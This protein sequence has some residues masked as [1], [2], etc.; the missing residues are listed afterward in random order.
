MVPKIAA[1]AMLAVLAAC[2]N[3]RGSFCDLAAPI[4]LSDEQIATLTDEQVAQ[5]LGQNERGRVLCGW[6]R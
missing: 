3:P 4:R 5:F 6:A 2:A 1:V